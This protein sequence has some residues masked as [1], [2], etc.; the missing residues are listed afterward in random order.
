[1]HKGLDRPAQHRARALTE[2]VRL[3]MVDDD[4]AFGHA[5][6]MDLRR[7]GYALRVALSAKACIKTLSETVC[8]MAIVDA[9]LT[10]DDLSRL[11]PL[12][13]ARC[14]PVLWLLD[15]DA[16]LGAADPWLDRGDVC[17]RKPVGLVEL[18][19]SLKQLLRWRF[20]WL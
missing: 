20:G 12:L 16:P 11:R 7:M 4:A 13:R 8:D 2:R 17:L 1:M 6:T 19:R 15:P 5:L 9:H 18:E 10:Q 3:L 14:L